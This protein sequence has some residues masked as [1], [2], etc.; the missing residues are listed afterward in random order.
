MADGGRLLVSGFRFLF[1]LEEAAV[2]VQIR[3]RRF[4]D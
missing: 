1:A 2:S 3:L 4:L